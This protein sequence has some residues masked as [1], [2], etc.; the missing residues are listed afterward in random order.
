[1]HRSIDGLP[2]SEVLGQEAPLTTGG[3]EVK[4]GVDNLTTVLGFAAEL[5]GFGQK[6]VDSFPLRVSEISVVQSDFHRFDWAAPKINRN[7]KDKMSILYPAY[8]AV[9]PKYCPVF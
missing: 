2:W 9:F 6:Q 1:M 4:H 3:G 5:L 8:V 7:C